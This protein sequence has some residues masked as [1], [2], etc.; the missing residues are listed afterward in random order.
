MIASMPQNWTIGRAVV[1]YAQTAHV[2][3]AGIKFR[4]CIYLSHR[5]F[6]YYTDHMIYLVNCLL[7][8]MIKKDTQGNKTDISLTKL[9]ISFSSGP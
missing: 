3:S 8:E 6:P 9:I 2:F 7:E 5:N 1:Y 4:H